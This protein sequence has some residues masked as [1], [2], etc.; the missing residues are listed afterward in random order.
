MAASTAAPIDTPRPPARAL[1]AAGWML[2]S[3]L[4]FVL[5]AVAGRGAA[6]GIDT[7]QLMFW[8]SAIGLAILLVIAVPTGG[9]GRLATPQLGLHIGRNIVHYGAQFSWLYALTLLPLAQLFAQI[10]RAHV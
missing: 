9:L 1:A 2:V 6:P 10:G 5:V 3:L 8:R 4:S 7:F